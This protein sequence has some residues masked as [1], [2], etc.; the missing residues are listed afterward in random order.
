MSAHTPGPWFV[1]GN[2]GASIGARVDGRELV[3]GWTSRR[4]GGN[5]QADAKLIA[6]APSMYEYIVVQAEQF[7]DARAKAILERL[8]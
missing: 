8:K 5:A 3:I 7:G 1:F 2:F 4:I 6:L